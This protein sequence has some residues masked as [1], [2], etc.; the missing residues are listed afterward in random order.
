MTSEEQKGLMLGWRNHCGMGKG[1][2]ET[3]HPHQ[4]GYNLHLLNWSGEGEAEISVISS[5]MALRNLM[6]LLSGF[7]CLNDPEYIVH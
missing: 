4:I 5:V 1:I 3:I 7:I 2:N 6:F